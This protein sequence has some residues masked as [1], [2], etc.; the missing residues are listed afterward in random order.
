MGR[1]DS[2]RMLARLHRVQYGLH[3]REQATDRGFSASTVD[4]YLACGLWIRVHRFVY[5][6]SAFPPSEEQAALAACLA[7]DGNAVASHRK[8]ARLWGLDVPATPVPEVT[9]LPP[10]QAS[11]VG[12]KAYR[13]TRLDRFEYATLRFNRLTSPMRTLA[14]VARFVDAVVLELALDAMW[15]RKLVQPERLAAYL[16]DPWMR[17]R[18]GV[19]VLRRLVDARLGK[20]APGSDLETIAMR[21]L[22]E[23]GL[24]EPERQY[25][26]Q[27]P[28]G[29]RKLDLAY[30]GSNLA[31]ELNGFERHAGDRT[32]FDDD[33]VRRNDIEE[34][35]WRFREF[36]WTHVT[37]DPVYVV[38]TI[39]KALG[40]RP[41][42]WGN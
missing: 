8:A 7:C 23:G 25:P 32:V 12:V 26:I 4:R 6:D 14:D 31:I 13:T 9:P 18:A 34:M 10:S 33:H 11:P 21:V 28:H 35:G 22:M 24:P 17:T 29:L 19:H 16:A 40:M 30:P 2:K 37:T 1:T 41:I 15:R 42:R 20:A 5:R 3:T 39:G 36:T 38:T 27:T